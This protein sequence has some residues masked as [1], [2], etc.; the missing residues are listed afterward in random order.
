MADLK[1]VFSQIKFRLRRSRIAV[2]IILIVAILFCTGALITLRICIR[3]VQAS[4]RELR[5]RAVVLEQENSQI[6][7]EQAELGSVRSVIRIA[8]ERLGLVQPGT[9]LLTPNP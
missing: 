7:A 8:E 5:D 9:V 3:D 6:L 2:K 4:T 1:S